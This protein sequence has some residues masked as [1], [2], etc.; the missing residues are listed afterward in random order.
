[1]NDKICGY[2]LDNEQL[3]IVL[4]ESK[5]VLVTAGAGSGKTMTIL[6][7]INYL[8]KYKKIKPEEILCISFTRDSSISL[9]NK[10]RLEFNIDIDVYTFHKLSLNI[11]KDFNI[12]FDIAPSN[13]LLECIDEF[14]YKDV[15]ISK[16][17]MKIILKYMGER[18][19][20]NSSYLK[21]I[22][23]NKDKV[24]LLEKLILTFISLFKCNNYELKDFILFKTKIKKNIFTFY[25]NKNLLILCLNC[26]LKY[27]NILENNNMI[28]FD[29][30]I[31]NA[32][33]CAYSYN[34]KYKYIIIDEYQDTSFI[35]FNLIKKLLEKNDANLMVVGDDFQSIYKFTGCDIDLFLNFKT[36]FNNS[37]IMKIENTYRN[38]Q[39][40]ISVA[41]DFVMKN[42]RQ[43]RKDLKS[44]KHIK[45]P[46]E[47]YYY[48]NIYEGFIKLINIIYENNKGE[49]L[50][51]GRNNFDIDFLTK[52]GEFKIENDYIIYEKNKNIKLKYLTVHRSKGLESDNVII[53]NLTNKLLGFPNKIEDNKLL[54]L[55]SNSLDTYPFGEERR[56]FYVALTRTK[57]KVYLYVDKN[58]ESIF[59]K[60]L[61]KNYKNYILINF[62]C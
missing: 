55:V 33:R 21:Y 51:L 44:S 62:E 16:I 25:K 38:S 4:D 5:Y 17:H 28:D 58:R 56:L 45:Y 8:V 6:G 14:I 53:L 9:K 49:I 35:R 2:Y 61:L 57:N 37:K 29:D 32:T 10:I 59:V 31:I 11:L 22:N 19:K 26:Y 48:K 13:Y 47:I 52:K 30:M 54:S 34:K 15:Q 40:L 41:G 12:K 23:K 36:Y 46:I 27:K 43:I 24:K 3:K 60:E 7:K 20:N 42:K 50:I 39:E 1:M 18:Y